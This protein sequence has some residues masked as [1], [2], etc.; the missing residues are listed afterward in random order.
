[1][2]DARGATARSTSTCGSGGSATGSTD[3]ELYIGGRRVPITAEV[4]A[5]IDLPGLARLVV[6]E[7]KPVAKADHGLTVNALHLTAGGGETDI[8]I[9]SATSDVHNCAS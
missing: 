6:N 7:Q 5:E 3:V 2:I 8:V 9:A 4:N 1:V